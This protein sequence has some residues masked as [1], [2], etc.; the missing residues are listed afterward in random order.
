MGI[1]KFAWAQAEKF[2]EFHGVR[3]CNMIHFFVFRIRGREGGG[4]SPAEFMGLVGVS[5]F[6]GWVLGKGPGRSATKSR[7]AEPRQRA[8]QDKKGARA[9]PRRL[10]TAAVAQGPPRACPAQGAPT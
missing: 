2:I 10:L 3:L 9:V 4:V 8:L 5:F 7:S 6:A 1:F